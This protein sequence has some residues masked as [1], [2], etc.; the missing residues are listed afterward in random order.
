MI[1]YSLNRLVC[2]SS[3]SWIEENSHSERPGLRVSGQSHGRRHVKN[4]PSPLGLP[5][6]SVHSEDAITWSVFGPI[7]YAAPPVRVSFYSELLRLVD[8]GLP[9]PQT[10]SVSL[11]RRI[12]YPDS[13]VSGGPGI[14]FMVISNATVVLGE[15][16]WL[17]G[18]VPAAVELRE[19]TAPGQ[20]S[21]TASSSV[22]T[23]R[24]SADGS[25]AA[26]PPQRGP[27]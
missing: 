26:A 21:W 16:K 9:T 11:W 3:S 15:A 27:T 1:C 5:I 19:V 24:S 23:P 6:R 10:A 12:P 18:V 17:S 22:R 2:I 13:L 7:C 4:A 8:K 14:D 20:R 25:I